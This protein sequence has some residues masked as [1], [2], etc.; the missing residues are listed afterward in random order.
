MPEFLEEDFDAV[1]CDPPERL[2]DVES[3]PEGKRMSLSGIVTEVYIIKIFTV[4]ILFKITYYNV[5]YTY[6]LLNNLQNC[7][8]NIVQLRQKRQA[9]V[10]LQSPNKK[11][12]RIQLWEPLDQIVQPTCLCH[13]IFSYANCYLYS[14]YGI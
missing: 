14:R 3:L 8:V 10:E 4:Q 2:D 9:T 12:V 1:I 13:Y 5:E 6:N 7:Q 11:R